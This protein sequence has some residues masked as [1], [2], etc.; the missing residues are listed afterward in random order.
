MKRLVAD[1]FFTPYNDRDAELSLVFFTLTAQAVTGAIVYLFV[2]GTPQNFQLQATLLVLFLLAQAFSFLHLGRKRNAFGSVRG[3]GHSWLSAEIAALGLLS[4]LLGG[5]TLLTLHGGVPPWVLRLGLGAEVV[6]SLL[7]IVC[8]INCYRLPA[9]PLWNTPLTPVSFLASANLLG[10]H[11]YLVLT[12]SAFTF[13]HAL[14]VAVTLLVL[15]A[16]QLATLRRFGFWPALMQL[17][18]DWRDVRLLYMLRLVLAAM[19][20]LALIAGVA[21][22]PLF[23]LVALGEFLG[24]VL[25]YKLSPATREFGALHV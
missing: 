6:G 25:F 13:T 18:G 10:L 24:R 3:L 7:V 16:V 20:L 11:L 17:V 2:S 1:R 23:A 15:L 19:V 5:M 4:A 21:L 14:N 8:M 22:G 12:G 9:R